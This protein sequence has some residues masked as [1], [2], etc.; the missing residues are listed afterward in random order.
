[1]THPDHP[2]Q[3]ILRYQH[4]RRPASW[5]A[6][7]TARAVVLLIV[8]AVV[9]GA[10]AV[11]RA[12][13]PVVLVQPMTLVRGGSPSV[14]VQ[15]TGVLTATIDSAYARVP[16][17]L[18]STAFGLGT[19]VRVG[20]VLAHLESHAEAVEAE[21][22]DSL[23]SSVRQQMVR[24]QMDPQRARTSSAATTAS[25]AHANALALAARAKLQLRYVVSPVEGRVV[26]SLVRPGDSV[27]PAGRR[28]AVPVAE[29]A[30]AASLRVAADVP[31]GAA[32]AVHVGDPAVIQCDSIP[33]RRYSGS[34]A[35]LGL[36]SGGTTRVLV[37]IGDADARSRPGLRC[38][39]Q[40][41]GRS[42]APASPDRLF[43]PAA[44][45]HEDADQD[46]VWVLAGTRVSRRSVR[47]GPAEDGRREIRSGL[48]GGELVVVRGPADLVPGER[49]RAANAPP[50]P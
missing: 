34:V 5:V 38:A 10:V 37:A 35:A 40:I 7:Y 26:R 48:S 30:D 46:I 32:R 14:E 36:T 50:S 25:L 17:R 15:G 49:V 23:L 18:A 4:P 27:F 21:R 8:V 24:D 11:W 9:A 44:A 33:G 2:Q 41:T 12:R 6:R 20:Q 39:V 47:A 3:E 45:V 13:S 42:L 22:A 16:G 29:V 43:V 1:V 31:A 19:P 28:G